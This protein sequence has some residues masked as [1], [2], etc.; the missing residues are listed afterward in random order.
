MAMDLKRWLEANGLGKY[1]EVFAENDV[2][3]EA[4]CLLTD[5]ELEKI[6]VSRACGRARARNEKRMICS[7]RST[8]GSP[9]DSTARI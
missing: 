6:R 1:V 7:H 4:L 5:S 3:L 2:D 8:T 9:K